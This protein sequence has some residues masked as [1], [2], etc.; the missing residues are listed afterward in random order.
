MEWIKGNRYL[1][2]SE[3]E[4]NATIV[5]SYL[6]TRGWSVNAIAGAL[7]NIQQESTINPAIWE[8]LQENS[9]GFGLVGWTPYTKYTDWAD[10]KG[11][12]WDDGDGQLEWLNTEIV[13]GNH[14]D[15]TVYDMTFEEFKTSTK[16][17]S[18]LC[19]V[20]CYSFEKPSAPAIA[21]RLA[22]TETWYNFIL[23]NGDKNIP[24]IN[25]AVEWAVSIAKDDS[26]GYD[27]AN[28]WG[29]DYDCSSL[30][31][32]AYENAGC[33]VKTNGAVNTSTML[34]GFTASG[35]IAIPY[36][37]GMTLMKG[38]VLL[39]DGHTE[40]YIGDGYNVGAHINEL[41]KTTGGVTGDQNAQEISITLF[42]NSGSWVTV[43]RLPVTDTSG[44]ITSTKKSKGF[45]FILYN[46]RRRQQLWS[47]MM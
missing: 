23:H 41:D 27:Q 1:S 42:A 37:S 45:N 32:T 26:H 9:G 20:F 16:D 30:L 17:S 44:V 28:R 46:R 7:G 33:P 15:S 2:Q 35:F 36:K 40:M 3:M 14:W 25:D 5:S 43:L 24:I 34:A 10:S 8:G 11:Y 31:I 18:Y 12:E 21:K 22:F 4:N 39:R 19:K 29:P 38:D 6:F 13:D 47:R